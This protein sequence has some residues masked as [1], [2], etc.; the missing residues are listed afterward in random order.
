MAS[1]EDDSN[2]RNTYPTTKWTSSPVLS[3]KNTGWSKEGLEQFNE[4]CQ[5]EAT[6][7]VENSAVDFDSLVKKQQ[8][9]N[10]RHTQKKTVNSVTVK[11]YIDEHSLCY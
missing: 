8:K 9:N 3:G 6:D 5:Q 7:R 1:I 2:T 4:L 11:T 10:A